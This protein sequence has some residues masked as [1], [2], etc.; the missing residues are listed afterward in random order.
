MKSVSLRAG[1][2]YKIFF[3]GVLALTFKNKKKK[4]SG[5][6]SPLKT[7]AKVLCMGTPLLSGAYF[8]KGVW[9]LIVD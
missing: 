9:K 8:P 2:R 5:G 3:G 6:G 1:E 4:D 7:G